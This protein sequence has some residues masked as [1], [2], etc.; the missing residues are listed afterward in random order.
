MNFPENFFSFLHTIGSTGF[1]FPFFFVSSKIQSCRGFQRYKFDVIV[2]FE[3]WK[4]RRFSRTIEN[5]NS[6]RVY[7]VVCD[8]LP[9]LTDS[10]MNKLNQYNTFAFATIN[11]Q[12]TLTCTAAFVARACAGNTRVSQC[13]HFNHTNELV[14][15]RK[16]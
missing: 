1:E 3:P 8:N 15:F 10:N 9:E 6:R 2:L 4:I 16:P 14:I 12:F 5:D 7:N 11:F 13:I